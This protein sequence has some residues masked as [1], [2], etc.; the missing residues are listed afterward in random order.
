[1]GFENWGKYQD[2]A[3]ELEKQWSTKVTM[4]PIVIG[5]L[6]TITNELVQEL[7]DLE[8]KGQL[9]IRIDQNTKMSPEALRR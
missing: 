2:V 5:V 6:G 9:E 8:I 3:R 7:E 4:T 1:M